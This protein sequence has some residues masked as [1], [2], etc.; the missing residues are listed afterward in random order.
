MSVRGASFRAAKPEQ[1]QARRRQKRDP[2][3]S[4]VDLGFRCARDS[5]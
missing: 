2:A 3:T 5:R 4:D 1:A